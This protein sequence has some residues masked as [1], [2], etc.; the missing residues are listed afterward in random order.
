M[1]IQLLIGGEEE[2]L[3]EVSSDD[4]GNVTIWYEEYQN[5]D[6]DGDYYQDFFDWCESMEYPLERVFIDRTINL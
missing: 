4:V 1:L 6:S 5:F 2:A 3:I